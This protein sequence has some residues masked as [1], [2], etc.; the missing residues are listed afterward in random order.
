M[1]YANGNWDLTALQTDPRHRRVLRGARPLRGRP[2]LRRGRGR[3]RQR[4]APHRHRRRPGPGVR[5]RP[6][7]RAARGRPAGR[8][9][10]GRLEPGRRPVRVRRTTASSRTSSTPPAT[11]WATT[12]PS[13]PTS[14]APASTSRQSVSATVTRHPAPDL[15]DGLRPLRRRPR[16]ATPR[17]RR[18][19]SSAAPA[20]PASSRA[21]TTTCPAGAPSP[22]PARRPPSPYRTHGPGRASR[23]SATARSVT[24]AWLP[25]AWADTYTVLRATAPR[26]AVRDDRHRRRRD[27]RTPT[28]EC[29]PGGRT[30]TPS[31][32]ANSQGTSG[33]SAPV[34]AAAGLPGPW[35]TRDVGDVQIPGS[36]AF[37][38]E[39]FVLEALA[40]PPT[41]TAW[42]TCRCAA[43]ARSRR[44][45]C[46]R[47][48]RST[49]RSASAVRAAL[50]ADAAH[51]ADA[52]PG[53]AAAHLERGVD[54]VRRRSGRI[55]GTGS[56]PVPPSQQQAI[57]TARG[58]PDLRPRHAARVGDPAGGPVRRGRRATA[59]GCGCPT[60]SG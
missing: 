30:T 17:T 40:A 52:D 9:R 3:Q 13:S 14:T 56:T 24:V 41:P 58:L 16:A 49:P 47:S 15:R 29:A 28:A 32:A 55:S 42:S 4:P 31:T 20:A 51:A 22:T 60:G 54:A 46:G 8:R 59:T 57:T 19:P 2:A 45:S 10:A 34:A 6:G 43:T 25:S 26:R 48:A 11:T 5:P 7:P 50:D 21:A 27:R 1:L 39:R 36:A 38:G 18:R 37:D 44:G 33:D 35:T 23:R 12:C 53:A